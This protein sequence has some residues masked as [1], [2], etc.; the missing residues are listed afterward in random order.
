MHVK[1][2]PLGSK[3]D[4]HPGKVGRGRSGHQKLPPGENIVNVENI[5]NIVNIENN[6][7]IVNIVNIVNIDNIENIVNIENNENIL[8]AG[9]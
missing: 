3:V 4:S 1:E 6:E 8:E 9:W 5:E 2:S 7:N